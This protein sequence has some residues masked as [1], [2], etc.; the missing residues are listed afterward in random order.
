MENP[1]KNRLSEF[2]TG[3]VDVIRSF[4]EGMRA[5]VIEGGEQ[6]EDFDVLNGT[7]Q[8]C[9]LAP[10]LFSI[11]FAMMLIVA[12][13][14]CDLGIGVQFTDGSVFD[15]RRLQARTKVHSAI[16]RDLLFADDCALVAHTLREVQLIFDRFLNTAQRFGLTVSLK[17]TE[18][19]HQSYPPSKSASALVTAGSN[20][21]SS[22]DKFCYLGSFLSNMVAVDPLNQSWICFWQTTGSSMESSQ[23]L[24]EYKDCSIP[25]RCSHISAIWF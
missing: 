24:I 19:L 1:G 7:K 17:K 22:V 11:F 15:V 12:F 2:P 18:A 16:I 9:M 25:C 14:D 21:L 3:L 8:G 6:S 20:Q 13:K 4:H 10:L 5:W 23:H